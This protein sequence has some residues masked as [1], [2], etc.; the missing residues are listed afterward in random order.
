MMSFRR[1]LPS[2]EGE[3]LYQYTDLIIFFSLHQDYLDEKLVVTLTDFACAVYI[4]VLEY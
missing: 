1:C 4:H 3:G 2:W